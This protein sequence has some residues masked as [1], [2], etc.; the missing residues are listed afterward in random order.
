MDGVL[1][2]NEVLDLPKR[3]KKECLIFKVDLEK[4]V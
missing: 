1:V 3:S 2:V 4:G